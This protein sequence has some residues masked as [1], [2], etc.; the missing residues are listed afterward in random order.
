MASLTQALRTAQ[1]GLLVNQ[2]TLNVVA[3]N[4]AN[5]NTEGYSRKIVSVESQVIVGVGAGVSVSDITRQVDEGLMKSVRIELGE[6]HALIVQDNY[7]AR[8]QD[9]FGTP[10]DNTSVAHLLDEFVSSL[11]TL[12]LSPDKSVQQSEVI[13]RANDAVLKLQDMSETIQELRLQAD[14]EIG[15][16]VTAMNKIVARIDQLNDDIVSNSSVGRDVS[17]LR[18]QRDA[19]LDELATYIDIRYFS[20]ADGDVV[21]FSSG[22]RTLVDTIPPVITHSVS[23]T[24]SSTSTHSE[25]D[26]AG[27]YVGTVE[28]RNDITN[29]LR[30][31]DLK[32]LVELRDKVL[33]NLQN[34]LDEMAAEMRDVFNQI[35]NRGVA[36]PGAQTYT[37][38]RTFVR[39]TEQTFTYSGTSDTTV[40]LFDANGDQT[41]VSTMRSADILNANN[42]TIDN[43][44]TKLQAW[45]RA[46]GA[47]SAT[48]IVNASGNFDINLNSTSVNLAFR[49]ET[50]TANGSTLQ[51][52]TLNFDANGDGNS[53]ESVSGLSNF[54]GLN[55]FFVTGLADNIHESNVLTSS[56]TASASQL[57]FRDA[58][59]TL[60]GSPLAVTAGTSLTDLATLITNNVTD[61]TASVVPDGSGVRLRIA[62]DQGSSMTVTQAAGNTFLTDISM[63]KADARVASTIQI[64]SDIFDQPSK[65]TTGSVLWDANKGASGEYF[66]S[67]GDNS[68][69]ESLASAFTSSNGF[70]TAGGLAS[71]QHTFTEYA[72]SI[73]S[74]NARQADTIE[75][76]GKSQRSLTESLQFKSDTS[77]GVN[78]DEEMS[79]LIIFEQAFNASAR[80]IATVQRML[81]ALEQV[82]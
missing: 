1:S 31:G 26:I 9:M 40:T 29:E 78:L 74:E 34:Q 3:N 49:D 10:N 56:F 47:A 21:V 41:A 66:M 6:L 55:D 24:V 75:S 62:H 4:I 42:S 53:D 17:D 54:L 20:R 72:S 58:T 81:D 82:V 33:P 2:Q 51:D 80:I 30:G 44:A 22:G 8:T 27:I 39:P 18:D 71:V 16:K 69:I 67:L 35:H 28:A 7:F 79:N 37:G 52:A 73:V 57:T 25:G 15:E 43:A 68:I 45:L 36:V 59:G 19:Q 12:T 60:T 5:V 77:R 14:V 23:A 61:V 65:I 38:S 46:N 48:V 13:R 11:E 70:D 63:H 50:A 32:G 76:N 64:R